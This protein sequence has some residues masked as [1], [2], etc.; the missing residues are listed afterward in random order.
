[1]PGIYKDGAA[2]KSAGNVKQSGF[3]GTCLGL[4]IVKDLVERYDGPLP[5][6]GT[7]HRGLRY[8]VYRGAANGAVV[9]Y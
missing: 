6:L 8:H 1:M 9:Q 3:A 5:R 7:Q 4:A 2:S